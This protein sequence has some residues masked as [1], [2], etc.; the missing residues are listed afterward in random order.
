M[1]QHALHFRRIG[2]VTDARPEAIA[3][4]ERYG[5]IMFLAIETIAATG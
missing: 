5:F 4:H 1:L 2:V 3:F